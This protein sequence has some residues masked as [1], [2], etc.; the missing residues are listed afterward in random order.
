MTLDEIRKELCKHGFYG[1][2]DLFDIFEPIME[3]YQYLQFDSAQAVKDW[4]LNNRPEWELEIAY[5][6]WTVVD[7]G[8]DTASGLEL[9]N[10]W[11]FCNR[12]FYILTENSWKLDDM[13]YSN[14]PL[15]QFEY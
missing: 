5:H 6:V 14:I 13:D 4:V 2:E 10:G 9:Q 11:H 8:D 3:D 15:I 12:M 7:V 1:S